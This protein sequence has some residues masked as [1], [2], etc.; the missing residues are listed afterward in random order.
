MWRAFQTAALVRDGETF[1]ETR[2]SDVRCE[3]TRLTTEEARSERTVPQSAPG[4]QSPTP[5]AVAERGVEKVPAAAANSITA[6]A[7]AASGTRLNMRLMTDRPLVVVWRTAESSRDRFE[8]FG[9]GAG[10]VS[11]IGR[12]ISCIKCPAR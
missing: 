5:A 2:P 10:G 9:G 3:L 6:T 1:S 12:N 11:F 8:L 7:R 4:V